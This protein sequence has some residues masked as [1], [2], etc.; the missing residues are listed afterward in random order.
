M[1]ISKAVLISIIMVTYS[2]KKDS[3]TDPIDN[4]TSNS[5]SKLKGY[6]YWL[7]SNIAIIDINFVYDA[8][9]IIGFELPQKP[10]L[11]ATFEKDSLNRITKIIQ[12][13]ATRDILYDGDKLMEITGGPNDISFE[14]DASNRINQI[15]YGTSNFYEFTYTGNNVTQV[16]R[17]QGT[18]STIYTIQYDSEPNIF[19][20]DINMRV[21]SIDP[22]IFG[23]APNNWALDYLLTFSEN[24]IKKINYDSK[25]L[26]NTYYKTGN[27]LDSIS[28]S[29]S[30]NLSNPRIFKMKY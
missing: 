5:S 7:N 19:Y 13:S 14:F 15:N 12:S 11:A 10:N 21:F 1:N 6:E 8:N 3:N 28:Q 22:A 29:M 30:W 2:C 4:N 25:E 17:T 9:M 26:N 20:N 27:R 23:S 18:N 24:N 16:E